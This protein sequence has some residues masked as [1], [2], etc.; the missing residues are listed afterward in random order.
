M[1]TIQVKFIKK[2]CASHNTKICEL[3]LYLI[4]TPIE[5]IFIKYLEK[6]IDSL[7]RTQIF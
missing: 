6:G 5:I 3:P 4:N 1:Y 2:M 7:P